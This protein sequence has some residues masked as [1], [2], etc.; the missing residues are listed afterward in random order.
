[1]LLTDVV[2]PVMSGATLR[3]LQ[4]GMKVLFMSGYPDDKIVDHGAL[5]EG[6]V[7]LQ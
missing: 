1:M 4:P 3:P 2:M 7:L 6:I 5:A